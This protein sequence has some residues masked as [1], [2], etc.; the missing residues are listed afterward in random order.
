MVI[1]AKQ[2]QDVKTE[3]E[4]I[5]TLKTYHEGKTNHRGL[6]HT[7]ARIKRVY[8]WPKL[9]ESFQAYINNFDICLVTKYDRNPLKS[10]LISPLRP[11]N[12]FR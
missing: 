6:D 2:L 10:N 8:Y 9:R 4:I 12:H 1:C 5:E 11:S 7:E 3:D